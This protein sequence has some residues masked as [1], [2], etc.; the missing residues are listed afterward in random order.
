MPLFDISLQEYKEHNFI[1]REKANAIMR[2]CI[3]VLENIHKNY[4]IH[5][6]IK[7]YNFMF[8]NME[9][10][11]ID[12]GF[13]T[14]YVDEE[15]RHVPLIGSQTEIIGTPK[16]ISYHIHDGFEP[17]R[18]DDLI[19]I[20]YIYLFLI[21][22]SLEWEN[23]ENVTIYGMISEINIFHSKNIERKRLKYIEN[24]KQ[25]FSDSLPHFVN[26]I[27]YCY[28]LGY[29]ENPKYDIIKELFMENN[30]NA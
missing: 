10:Y 22:G 20:G 29:D 24:L 12:F 13:A 6:D 2:T 8:K 28:S 18:R 21:N 19:S 30:I 16:Y 27:S 1:S 7:P 15:K 23:L 25:K 17:S 4:V 11:L 3:E 9:L 5:R 26:Y 14:F